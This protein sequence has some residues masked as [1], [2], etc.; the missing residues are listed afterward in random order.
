LPLDVSSDLM[1]FTRFPVAV[2]T[3]GVKSIL[4]IASTREL[5]ETLGVPVV[6]FGT[7][8]FPAFYRRSADDARVAPVD[9]RFDDVAEL[10]AFVRAELARSRRGIVVC[11]PIPARHE[12]AK[13]DW[14]TWLAE[15]NRRAAAA[16]T[17]GRGVTPFILGALHEISSGA[18]LKANLALVESNAGLAARLA[19]AMCA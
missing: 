17:G 2:V 13:A 7:D 9:E 10:A 19:A 15:A 14:D 6:G 4:D 18:T 11:N 8:A 1:A 16:G 5:L 3:S 12:I